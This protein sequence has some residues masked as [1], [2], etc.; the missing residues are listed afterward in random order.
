MFTDSSTHDPKI[1]IACSGLGAVR[2][3]YERY[4]EELYHLVRGEI[5]AVLFKGGP[6]GPGVRLPNASRK[7][8]FSKIF[9]SWDSRYE[10]EVLTFGAAL[11]LPLL[12]ARFDLLHFADYSLGAYRRL[13]KWLSRPALLFTNGA[14][15]PPR[16]YSE[17]DYIHL[18]NPVAYREAL[19]YGISENR[20]FMIPHGV[21][22]ERFEPVN[23]DTKKELR[24]T[25]GIPLDDFVVLSVGH[26]GEGSHKRLRWIIQEIG[27]VGEGVFLLLVGEQ[28]QTS[29]G[30]PQLAKR[31]LGRRVK[32]MT[33][34]ENAISDAYSQADLFVLA[35][36]R[37]A[38]GIVIIEAM[39]SGLPAI[40]HDATI[41][42]WIV[43]DGG[44][45]VDMTQRSK[46][47]DE[48]RFYMG[49]ETVRRR[50]AL[51]ART[52]A[53]KKFSWIALRPKYLEMYRAC[54][55]T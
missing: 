14:P 35:S 36:L 7:S 55:R 44:S 26:M 30:I 39:A 17:F 32:V 5:S 22:T 49:N 9:R 54:C 4:F 11:L 53:L 52:R 15:C 6:D 21:D 45:T 38:F 46:L 20:L 13:P 12:F 42:R 47:A 33:L 3:G 40:T 25:Y 29:R 51:R 8:S 23:T 16:A 10:F 37:E 48:V 28:D 19:N 43:A 41:M 27:E 34:P 1:A 2:R 24:R 50:R 31:K 18:V